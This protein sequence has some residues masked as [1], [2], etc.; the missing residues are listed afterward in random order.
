MDWKIEVFGRVLL[1]LLELIAIGGIIFNKKISKR[2]KLKKNQ[3]I[4][5]LII[6]IISLGLA[7]KLIIWFLK[8]N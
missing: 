1:I 6:G 3:R 7:I 4:I 2:F 8:N 5:L